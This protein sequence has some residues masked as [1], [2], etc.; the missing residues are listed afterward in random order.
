LRGGQ[1]EV[2]SWGTLK[3]NPIRVVPDDL[4]AGVGDLLGAVHERKI[5]E[6]YLNWWKGNGIILYARIP[7][8]NISIDKAVDA[9]QLILRH[10]HIPTG[11]LLLQP[12][13][14]AL[15]P[16]VQEIWEP[17]QLEREFS[18][19][20]LA[21]KGKD[22]PF[23]L[24][25]HQRQDLM[26]K[27]ET[28]RRL[29]FLTF[30]QDAPSPF[31]VGDTLYNLLHPLAALLF[32]TLAWRFL[33]RQAKNSDEVLIGRLSDAVSRFQRWDLA[34]SAQNATIAAE[35]LFEVASR[36]GLVMEPVKG[37]ALNPEDLWYQES[38][39][40]EFLRLASDCKDDFGYPIGGE[41]S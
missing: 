14:D 28:G 16:L 17:R 20:E 39:Q 8:R 15:R 7:R 5:Y 21:E 1:I 4:A 9:T 35:S 12:P 41:P 30:P 26:D 13:N 31:R 18:I 25:L 22:D 6:G 29:R 3:D 38:R 33:A 37:Y 11:V 36:A 10:S 2:G 19:N 24:T 27:I 32:R 34:H 40:A 23:A